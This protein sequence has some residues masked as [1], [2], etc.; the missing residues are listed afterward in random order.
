M[1]VSTGAVWK[2]YKMNFEADS[3]EPGAPNVSELFAMIENPMDV[4]LGRGEVYVSSHAGD[5][6]SGRVSVYSREGKLLRHITS[7]MLQQPN[8]MAFEL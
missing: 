6:D 3:R 1:G 8:M 4:C 2:H 5:G 7:P